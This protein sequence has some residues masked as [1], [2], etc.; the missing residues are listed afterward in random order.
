MYT[1]T[2]SNRIVI[3]VSPQWNLNPKMKLYCMG[4]FSHF[5][6]SVMTMRKKKNF[7][8][9]FCFVLSVLIFCFVLF[10]LFVWL[11][12]RQTRDKPDWYEQID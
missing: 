4:K 10:F 8:W 12:H 7:E 5:N 2:M 1:H 3:N 6:L 11:Y 9:I